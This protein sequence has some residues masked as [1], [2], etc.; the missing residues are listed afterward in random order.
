MSEILPAQSKRLVGYF[1]S[2]AIHAQ[3]YHVTDI[4]AGQL[5]HVIYAFANVSAEGDCVSVNP[6]DD[7]ANFPQLLQLKQQ[8]PNLQILISVGGASHSTNFGAVSATEAK[9]SHFAQSCVQFMK[10][11]GFDGIDIDWES[12]SGRI[13]CTLLRFSRNCVAS[14][15]RKAAPTNA[16]IC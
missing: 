13:D 10:Q 7:A 4:P 8:Y 12:Q 6:D 9:R 15:T 11:H 16:I 5:T 14:W 2:W 1:P 3:N